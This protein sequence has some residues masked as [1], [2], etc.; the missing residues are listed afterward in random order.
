MTGVY[1]VAEHAVRSSNKSDEIRLSDL[2]AGDRGLLILGIA[3]EDGTYSSAPESGTQLV[4]GDRVVLYGSDEEHN[5]LHMQTT[6]LW[7]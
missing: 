3:R 2:C 7:Q 4:A 6:T 5:L 1:T